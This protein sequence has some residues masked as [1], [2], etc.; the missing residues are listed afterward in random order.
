MYKFRGNKERFG[1]EITRK[2]KSGNRSVAKLFKISLEEIIIFDHLINNF[3]PP[4]GSDCGLLL[5]FFSFLFNTN[6]PLLVVGIVN[7]FEY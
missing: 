3:R 1:N 5:F 4:C 7:L 6:H 2:K